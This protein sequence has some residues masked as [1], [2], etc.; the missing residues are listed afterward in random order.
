MVTPLL[1]NTQCTDQIIEIID[2]PI[3]GLMVVFDSNAIYCITHCTC[4]IKGD[5]FEIRNDMKLD[6]NWWILV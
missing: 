3:L 5:G 6:F 2:Q 4:I 1:N